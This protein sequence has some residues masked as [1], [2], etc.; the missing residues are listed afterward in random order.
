MGKPTPEKHT[1][2]LTIMKRLKDF[3]TKTHC[4]SRI[5]WLQCM[6]IVTLSAGSVMNFVA[7]CIKYFEIMVSSAA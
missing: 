2:I 5:T 6:H 1:Y 3:V 7:I 4:V